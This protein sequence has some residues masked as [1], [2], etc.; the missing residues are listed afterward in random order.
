MNQGS[1]V[2]FPGKKD[3]EQ[4]TGEPQVFRASVG[5]SSSVASWAVSK[6]SEPGVSVSFPEILS[7]S[8]L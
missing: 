7:H 3:Q 2:C 1:F 4:C 8:G 5:C 6:L